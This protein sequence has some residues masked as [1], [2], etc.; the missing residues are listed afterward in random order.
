MSDLVPREVS[1]KLNVSRPTVLRWLRTGKLE[2]FRVGGRWRVTPE[3][4]ADFLAAGKQ[5]DNA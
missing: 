1:E 2:G 4:L 3:A 5:G